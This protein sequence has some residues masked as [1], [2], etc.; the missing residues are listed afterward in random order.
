L[1]FF[2]E[3]LS[4]SQ[5]GL[6]KRAYLVSLEEIIDGFGRKSSGIRG[7]CWRKVAVLSGT[8]AIFQT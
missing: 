2:R 8:Y 4:V 3:H 5:S 1:N 7:K 6:A